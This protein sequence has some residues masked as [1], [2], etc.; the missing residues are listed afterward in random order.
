MFIYETNGKLNVMFQATQIPVDGTPDVQLYKEDDVVHVFID[1][2]E[3][4]VEQ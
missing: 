1:G 2:K 3:V 4:Q